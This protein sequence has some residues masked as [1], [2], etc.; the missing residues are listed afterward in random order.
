MLS[1]LVQSRLRVLP[2]QPPSLQS[3]EQSLLDKQFWWHCKAGALSRGTSCCDDEPSEQKFKVNTFTTE[4]ERGERSLAHFVLFSEVQG[5]RIALPSL[6]I[7]ICCCTD[8]EI[9]NIFVWFLWK[10]LNTKEVRRSI[11][12]MSK[13]ILKIWSWGKQGWTG[14]RRNEPIGITGLD[15][16][17]VGIRAKC[18]A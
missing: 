7:L 9:A 11:L 5:E 8:E 6:V 18:P 3:P 2:H 13:R 12:M 10:I 16:W 15:N 17:R 14:E 1:E 4:K